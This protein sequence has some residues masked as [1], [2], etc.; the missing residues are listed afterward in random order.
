MLSLNYILRDNPVLTKE[1]RVRMRGARAYWILTGYLAFLS[2]ILFFQYTYWWNE[3]VRH[4]HGLASG[5][6]VGQQFFYYI[7]GVQAFLVAFI[8]PAVTSGA[9]TIEKEQRTLEMLEMTRLP[10]VSIIAGKLLSAIGFVALL[11]VSSLPLTSLCF[12]L[13]GVSPGQVIH[14]YLLLLAGSF[15]AGSLGLVWSSVARTTASAVVFTYASLLVPFLAAVVLLN[16]VIRPGDYDVQIASALAAGLYGIQ[17]PD[18]MGNPGPFLSAWDMRHYFGL[19]VPGWLAPVF[20]YCMIG[21]LLCAA[22]TVRLYPFPERNGRVIKALLIAVFVQQLFFYFGARFYVFSASAPP[23][24]A[25]QLATYPLLTMLLY[26]LLLLLAC[27][28]IF[29][30]SNAGEPDVPD[31]ERPDRRSQRRPFFRTHAA[32]GVPF[33]LLL[34]GVVFGM[35]W[36]SFA[37]IGQPGAA[38]TGH[39][40]IPGFAPGQF[41]TGKVWMQTQRGMSFV[42]PGVGTDVSSG[43]VLQVG[44]AVLASVTGLSALGYLFSVM[45]RNRWVAMILSYGTLALVFIVPVVATASYASKPSAGPSIL[46]NLFYLNPLASLSEATGVYGAFWSRLPFLFRPAPMWIATTA[47]YLTITVAA[48]LVSIPFATRKPARRVHAL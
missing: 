11:L 4:G 9:I 13:G 15:V 27:I 21:L 40:I 2:L 38:L 31:A 5:S 32:S 42:T 35:Y 36:L 33:L 3:A 19:T 48:A 10:R 17:I 44:I 24:M 23:G 41:A 12:F 37:L 18:D 46:I 14:S 45:T 20:T 39:F 6:K 34:T 43:G 22:A 30:T 29:S 47:I 28:P 7:A 1:L 26:P 8:T 16:A 25:A